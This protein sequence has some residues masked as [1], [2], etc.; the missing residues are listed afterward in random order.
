MFRKTGFPLVD[1][2]I[3]ELNKTGFMHNR[4]RMLVGNFNATFAY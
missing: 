4:V 3:R 2:G 1:V